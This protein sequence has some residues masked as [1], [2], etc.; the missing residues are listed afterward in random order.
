[1]DVRDLRQELGLTPERMEGGIQQAGVR[2]G[3][4][5][6]DDG[7][8]GL[9]SSSSPDEPWLTAYAAD[10]LQRAEAQGY[11]LPPFLRRG[12][13]DWL[14]QKVIE[15]DFEQND[16]SMYAYAFYVLAKAQAIDPAAV[17]YF[18]DTWFVKLPNRMAE[19]H[20]ATALV[21]VHDE[22][23]A[24][25]AFSRIFDSIDRDEQKGVSHYGSRV[26]DL[27]A[28]VAL[29]AEAGIPAE[30][31]LPLAEKL[32]ALKASSG[33]LTT[34]EQARLIAANHALLRNAQP[35]TLTRDGAPLPTE[36]LVT[37]AFTPEDLLKP[38]TFRNA[39]DSPVRV[40][41][42][43]DGY[44][45]ATLPALAQGFALQ[46]RYVT[47]GGQ[48]VDPAKVRQNDMLVVLI[49]GKTAGTFSAQQ[50]MVVDLLPAGLEIENPA[51]GSSKAAEELSWLPAQSQPAFQDR[52]DDRY[53][54]ALTLG[55]GESFALAYL[56]RAVTPGTYALPP[57]RVEDLYHLDLFA[58]TAPGQMVIVPAGR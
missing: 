32:A 6:K 38:V 29:A 22:A 19:A 48:P 56:V 52:R 26:S 13:I 11:D 53:V 40:N 24:D 57:V 31:L 17:R 43:Q 21:L 15:A 12:A 44:P 4:L 37:A 20:L 3:E 23:R 58:R 2:L 54:A 18:Y 50:V 30:R 46:R 28:V 7:A 1:V 42:Q 41:L 5:Q 49:E 25:A 55:S 8:F 10:F 33:A 16:L 34:Q 9:W 39:G 35:V 45:E 47:L 51:F 14:K 36:P 27:A